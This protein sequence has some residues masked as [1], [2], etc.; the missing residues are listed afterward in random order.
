MKN[1]EIDIE[2]VIADAILRAKDRQE[3]YKKEY[4]KEQD[5]FLNG[6]IFGMNV[7]F[8]ILKND[9]A[10]FRKDKLKELGLE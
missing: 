7:V 9:V 6:T 10:V 1:G 4:E 5:E 3:E 8:D 2:S